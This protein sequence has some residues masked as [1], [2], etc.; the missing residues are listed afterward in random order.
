M[1]LPPEEYADGWDVVIDTG[2]SAD[3][4][5]VCRAGATFTMAHRSLW[6]SA[7]TAA[8]GR[9]RPL[10]RRLGRAGPE[11]LIACGSR[12]HLPAADHRG[13]RPVRGRPA[14]A[15]PPRARRRLGLPVAAARGGAREHARLRRR[16]V[17][18]HRR[19]ARRGRGPR[20]AVGR[21][22]PARAW[23]CSSTSCPTTSASPRRRR[24][25]GG[26]TCSSTAASPSTRRR[27]TSSGPRATASC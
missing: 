1:T 17:R 9:A 12:P 14:A 8:R 4:T 20:H 25:R 26:G 23:A 3:E 19:L 16:R 15:L 13:L 6:C 22:A 11:V 7:S 27:S 21:G 18:P 5:E 24:R 2:G 10:G